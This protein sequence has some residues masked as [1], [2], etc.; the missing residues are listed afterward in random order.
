[1]PNDQTQ[2]G[3]PLPHPDNVAREDAQRIRNAISQI[4][5]DIAEIA[6]RNVIATEDTPGSVRLATDAERIAGTAEDR[7]LTVKRT[8]DMI[9]ALLSTVETALNAAM[10]ALQQTTTDQLSQNESDVNKAIADLNS[11]VATQLGN[12]TNTLAGKFDKAGGALSGS[13]AID[14]PVGQIA[15]ISGEIGGKLRWM[16]ALGAG[17]AESGNNAGSN[18]Q[19]NRHNDA[20]AFLGT[21]IGINRA[22]GDI[23]L[24]GAIGSTYNISGNDLRATRNDGQGYVFFGTGQTYIGFNGSNFV[25]TNWLISPN[26]QRY[27][28]LNEINNFVAQARFVY[29]GDIQVDR[30]GE[31]E[32][33]GAC[34]TGINYGPSNWSEG[35]TVWY[36]LRALQY[37]IPNVGWVGFGWS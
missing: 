24:G 30:Q 37:Y 36:R 13:V 18:L 14:M 20:G 32:S 25:A 6:D 29:V 16:L 35:N 17:G 34:V 10:N 27:S 12:F 21:A 3:Y 9:T 19:L 5:D 15:S 1:M 31:V 33:G 8:K 23:T 11:S 7:V 26:G 22:T 28:A 4:S 2:R